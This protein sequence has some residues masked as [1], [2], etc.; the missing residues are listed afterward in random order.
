M[1]KRFYFDVIVVVVVILMAFLANLYP[2]RQ[3]LYGYPILLYGVMLSIACACLLKWEETGVARRKP[4]QTRGEHANSTQKGPAGPETNPGPSCCEATALNHCATV[5]P[6][7][8]M[9]LHGF[10]NMKNN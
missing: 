4:T 1:R 3:L 9:S 2:L 10:F 6:L 5:L 8:S 7:I